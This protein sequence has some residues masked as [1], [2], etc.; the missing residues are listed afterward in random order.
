VKSYANCVLL[1]NA[2]REDEAR[3]LSQVRSVSIVQG[4][5]HYRRSLSQQV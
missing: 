3:I 4:L 1:G 2:A 5:G